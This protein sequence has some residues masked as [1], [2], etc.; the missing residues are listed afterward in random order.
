MSDTKE[1]PIEI[2]TMEPPSMIN[3]PHIDPLPERT[4]EEKAEAHRMFHELLALKT[5]S[6]PLLQHIAQLTNQV[7]ELTKQM[8]K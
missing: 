7:N 6:D 4:E 5:Q 3:I 2:P 8:K 1:I